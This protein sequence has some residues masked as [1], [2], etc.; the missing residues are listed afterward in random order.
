[1]KVTLSMAQMVR[2]ATA[3]SRA[4]CETAEMHWLA[5][6]TDCDRSPLLDSAAREVADL[7]KA[8]RGEFRRVVV[9]AMTIYAR[10]YLS[11]FQTQPEVRRG[12]SYVIRAIIREARVLA[13]L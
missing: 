3:T 1:M 12:V 5:R 2:L 6:G 10:M 13:S 9:S 11:K 7:S 8:G 4:A